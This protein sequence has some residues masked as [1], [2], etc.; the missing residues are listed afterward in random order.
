MHASDDSELAYGTWREDIRGSHFEGVLAHVHSDEA[1]AREL[2]H[3]IRGNLELMYP[4]MTVL[5]TF[6]DASYN[7]HQWN[8]QHERVIAQVDTGRERFRIS[9]IKKKV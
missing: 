6:Y 9:V 7:T 4:H 3:A 1:R 2:L 8:D 5:L